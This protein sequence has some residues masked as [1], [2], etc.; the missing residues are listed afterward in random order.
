MERRKNLTQDNSNDTG[1]DQDQSSEDSPVMKALRQ[2]IKDLKDQLKAAPDRD[3]LAAEIRAELARDSAIEARLV[4]HKIPVGILDSVKSKLGDAEATAEAV[5]KALSDIG[6]SVDGTDA[7]SD[8]SNQDSQQQ[9][10]LAGVASLSAQVQSAAGQATPANAVEAVNQ[11]KTR[12]E[13]IEAARKG[14]F[15]AG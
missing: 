8:Q 11:A 14:G 2:Q 9:G 4:S 5:D 15:L 7:G 12:E 1:N 6:F 10:D 13:L 3:S